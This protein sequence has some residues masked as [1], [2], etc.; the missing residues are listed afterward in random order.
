ML[1]LKDKH[2][3]SLNGNFFLVRMMGSTTGLSISAAIFTSRLGRLLST[4]PYQLDPSGVDWNALA[5]I[6]PPLLREQVL[7]AVSRALGVSLD[8]AVHSFAPSVCQ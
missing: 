7:T 5:S 3:A 8:S 4:V 6:E 1:V 2:L